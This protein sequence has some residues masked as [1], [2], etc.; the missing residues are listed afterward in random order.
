MRV[1]ITGGVGEIGLAVSNRLAARGYDLR[2]ID[3]LPESQVTNK[4][5][6]YCDIMDY[7]S[8]FAQVQGCDMI[9]HLAALKNPFAGP[10]QDVFRINVAG[11]FNVFEAA[12]QAGI[13]RVVQAS[14]INAIG[15]GWNLGDFLPRYFPLD[16][17]HPSVSTDSYAFSKKMVE[18]IGAYYWRRDGISSTALRFPGVYP[19]DYLNSPD[20]L[21]WRDKMLH[22]LE[23]FTQLSHTEQRQQLAQVH[24]LSMHY[25]AAR[26]MEYPY[27]ESQAIDIG[28]IHEQ[29][30]R[31][32]TFDRY[33]LWTWLDARDAAQA[34]EKSLSAD[35][36]G[37]H[38]LFI[39][40]H[41]NTLNYD[42][43][44][45]ANLFFPQ[46]AEWKQS[47]TGSE[48]LVSIERSRQ[49]IGFEPEH[50]VHQTS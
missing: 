20:Y 48:A 44:V 22:F 19:A 37:S 41:H 36:E 24:P 43:R 31:A 26:L 14:S 16:E 5:Y 12:A 11:T 18:D 25:R 49:L 17:D 42:S 28:L 10:T 38:V 33:Y 47:V 40:D 27:R 15:C 34:I 3:I 29:L 7:Q 45:L 50:S 35:Y 9:V 6:R 23:E 13:R 21:R 30:W 8:L 32:Y 4:H 1:L 2:L 46:V 39:N